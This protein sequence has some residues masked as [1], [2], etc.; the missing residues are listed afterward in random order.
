MNLYE[1]L[2]NN[3]KL[4]CDDIKAKLAPVNKEIIIREESAKT[5]YSN[6]NILEIVS[7]DCINDDDYGIVFSLINK[8]ST[9]P[10][11]PQEFELSAI[12]GDGR[13]ILC[14]DFKT[15]SDDLES[16]IKVIEKFNQNL[17]KVEIK[18]FDVLASDY[19]IKW[20]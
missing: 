11:K 4:K 12:K 20:Q 15:P 9:L 13:I 19:G 14:F 17:V 5:D 1:T 2:L 3:F 6:E 10:S 8:N 18:M 7:K 16:E